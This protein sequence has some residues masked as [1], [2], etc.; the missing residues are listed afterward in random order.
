MPPT[1]SHE[2]EWNSALSRR[3]QLGGGVLVPHCPPFLGE[4]LLLWG[5]FTWR[6]ICWKMPGMTFSTKTNTLVVRQHRVVP[7]GGVLLQYRSRP[8]PGTL[9]KGTPAAW[10]SYLL[11]GWVSLCCCG[12]GHGQGRRE[13]STKETGS[14]QH[15]SRGQDG[16]PLWP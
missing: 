12:Q 3:C 14:R 7:G 1:L 2:G 5:R 11:T 15:L 6:K 9:H 10:A 8:A 13:L 4:L 16:V